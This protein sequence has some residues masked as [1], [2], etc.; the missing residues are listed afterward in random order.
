MENKIAQ[1]TEALKGMK[2]SEWDR[3]KQQI[4]MQYNS[5]AAKVELDDLELLKENLHREFKC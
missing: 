1:I 2:R 5:K 4:D 3:V